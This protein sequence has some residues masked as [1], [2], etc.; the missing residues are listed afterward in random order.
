MRSPPG[1]IVGL[2]VGVEVEGGEL[3]GLAVAVGEGLGEG[4]GLGVGVGVAG[5]T[6]LNSKAPMSQRPTRP[7]PR[8]SSGNGAPSWSVQPA[9][10]PLLTAGL[11]PGI[12]CVFVGPPFSSRFPNMGSSVET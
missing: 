12:A 9:R 5:G 4:V 11:F 6:P 3:V 2:A 1:V 10:L 8:W 7:Y